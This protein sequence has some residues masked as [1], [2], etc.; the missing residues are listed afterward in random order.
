MNGR[1]IAA[2]VG[3]FSICTLLLLSSAEEQKQCSVERSKHARYVL[4]KVCRTFDIA[5]SP[6]FVLFCVPQPASQSR[7]AGVKL[8]V[9]SQSS[10]EALAL[11]TSVLCD[12]ISFQRSTSCIMIFLLPVPS[13]VAE[14]CARH[15]PLSSRHSIPETPMFVRF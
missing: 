13:T 3:L 10:L 2:S 8:V 9:Y 5:C 12:S 4:Y 1:F 6:F 7:V 14:T 11:K 15:S